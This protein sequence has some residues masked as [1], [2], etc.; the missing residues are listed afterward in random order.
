MIRLRIFT[1]FDS[2]SV[3]L[4]GMHINEIAKMFMELLNEDKTADKFMCIVDSKT[5][6]WN[7]IRISMIR[8]MIFEQE[9]KE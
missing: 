3:Y 1:E 9:E 6:K 5:N 7:L 2:I 4:N 8:R